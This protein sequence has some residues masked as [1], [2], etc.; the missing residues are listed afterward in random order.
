MFMVRKLSRWKSK[1]TIDFE[2][3]KSAPIAMIKLSRRLFVQ[4]GAET[5][6][7]N[8]CLATGTQMPGEQ[9]ESPDRGALSDRLNHYRLEAQQIV[10]AGAEHSCNVLEQR[11]ALNVCRKH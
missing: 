8:S 2:L 9:E 10:A 4:Q 6:A 11:R 1:Y 7:A 3:A 5:K